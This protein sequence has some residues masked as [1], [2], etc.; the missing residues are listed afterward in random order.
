MSDAQT[1]KVTPIPIEPA[2][3]APA[4]PWTDLGLAEPTLVDADIKRAFA[5]RL[6]SVRPDYDPDGFERLQAARDFAL[7]RARYLDAAARLSFRPRD[8][9]QPAPEFTDPNTPLEIRL[10]VLASGGPELNRSVNWDYLLDE[11]EREPLQDRQRIK[12]SVVEALL[13]LHDFYGAS[14]DRPS[15]Y[16][17]YFSE[18]LARTILEALASDQRG[19]GPSDTA[20]HFRW[21][22]CRMRVDKTDFRP[23]PRETKPVTFRDTAWRFFDNPRAESRRLYRKYR[24]RVRRKFRKHWKRLKAKRLDTDTE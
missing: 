4:D 11:L 24:N 9:G 5:M 18:P 2:D 22:R 3:N 10:V 6:R 12:S 20:L 21:L 19:D 15:M 1:P 14:Y 8:T 13:R 23:P 7:A 16:P 17:I